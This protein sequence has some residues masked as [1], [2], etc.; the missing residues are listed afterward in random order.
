MELLLET[1]ALYSLKLSLCRQRVTA[2]VLRDDP[3]MGVVIGRVLGCWCVGR[4]LKVFKAKSAALPKDLALEAIGGRNTIWGGNWGGWRLNL[5][6]PRRWRSFG[7]R[8]SNSGI[9]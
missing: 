2:R 4:I 3:L 7:V 5:A 9:T 1:V 6:L 8:F